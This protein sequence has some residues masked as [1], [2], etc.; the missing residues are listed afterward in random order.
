MYHILLP[1]DTDT[2]LAVIQAETVAN[3]PCATERVTATVVHVFGDETAAAET[4]LVDLPAGR[5]AVD[6]LEA[7]GVDTET[8]TTDGNAERQILRL[9]EELDVDM[10]VIGGH[11]RS[12]VESVVFGSLSQALAIDADRPVTIAGHT[13]TRGRRIE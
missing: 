12:L 3:L 4:A 8:V 10:L 6:A 5:A 1:I 9:A 7:G 2:E 13:G 11:R